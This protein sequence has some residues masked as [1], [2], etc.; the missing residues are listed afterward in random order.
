L[1]GEARVPRFT[2]L[3]AEIVGI[4]FVGVGL[5]SLSLETY[6]S[7]HFK[8]LLSAANLSRKIIQSIKA[9]ALGPIEE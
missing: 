4:M 1:A 5:F 7:Y 8:I 9:A 3:D 6:A 2:F